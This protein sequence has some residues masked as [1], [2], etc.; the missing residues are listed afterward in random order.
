MQ[1]VAN[2]RVPVLPVVHLAQVVGAA[3]M[4]VVVG[5]VTGAVVM[6][7]IRWRGWAWTCG[8][9]LL[10]AAPL[11]VVLGW[12]GAVCYDAAALSTVGGGLWRHLVDL[13]AGGDL[14]DRARDRIGPLTPYRRW[15]GWR[16]LRAGEW[17]TDEGVVIGFS[18]KGELVRVPIACGRAVMAI[19]VGA[20][21]SGKTILMLLLALAAIKRGS[22]VILVDPKG[23]DYVLEQLRQAAVRHGRRFAPWEPLG[24]VVYNPYAR[25]SDT[26][27]ADKLLAAEVFTEP[28]Y[29]RLA[30][31]YLGHVVRALK[32][33]DVEVSLATVV[34]HMHPGRLASLTRRMSPADARPLLAYLETLTPQQERDLAG[35]RDRLAILAESD[36]GPALDPTSDGVQVDLRE[37]LDAGDV[38]LFRLAADRRPLAA[39]MVGASIIQDLVALSDERQHGEQRPGLVIIDEF[40]ALGA[41]GGRQA[42]RPRAWWLAQPSAR[43]AGPWRS[44]RDRVR[45]GRPRREHSEPHRQQHRGSDGGPPEH[46]RIGRDDRCDR[47]HSWS[48]DHDPTDTRSGRWAPHR[49]AF[50]RERAGVRGPS[51]QDQKPRRRRGRRDRAPTRPDRHRPCLPPGFSPAARCRMLTQRDIA[52]AEWV[53]RQGAVRAEH[54]MARFSIGRTAAY[55]RLHQLVDFGLLQRHRLLYRDGG[56]LTATAEGLRCAGLDRLTPAR[57]SLALVPHMIAS[58]AFAADLEPRL[59]DEQLLSD[60]EH[61][62]AEIAAGEPIASAIIGAPRSGHEGLHRPD[63]ALIKRDRGDVVAVEIELTLKNRTRL[64][65]ILRGYLRNQ[66]VA[67]VRYHARREIAEAVERVARAVGAEGILELAPLPPDRVATSSRRS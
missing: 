33:A 29:Q 58:A 11:A 38:V 46:A 50:P 49:L 9:P 18:R 13:R 66:N 67:V 7:V 37:S 16:R 10:A 63:F 15:R 21:G 52:I 65:R 40:S 55:R 8:V 28:H 26:E 47:R 42:V 31:R 1:A 45:L 27:I 24:D 2:S 62:A 64:E 44:W 6:L 19:V 57:I 34:E 17:L 12:R 51:R 5:M 36:V 14:A 59:V 48:L 4:L 54:V 23:D 41:P 56:L 22:G 25:G 35:A 39:A 53:G 30:Q 32:L 43:H 3:A 20:T 61:R 60:R